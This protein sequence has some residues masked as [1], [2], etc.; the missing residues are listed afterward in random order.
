MLDK[1]DLV[2]RVKEWRKSSEAG[3]LQWIAWVDEKGENGK[4][5]PAFYD[6]AFLDEFLNSA[7][8][9]ST[10]TVTVA[11]QKQEFLQQPTMDP[12]KEALVRDIK[13]RQRSN[14]LKYICRWEEYCVTYAPDMRGRM[15]PERHEVPFLQAFLRLEEQRR[16]LV[17][18]NYS[19]PGS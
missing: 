16:R 8:R 14:D 12:L 18:A 17:A 4:R 5:D 13:Q 1:K 10:A 6:V 7:V 3:K 9:R 2:S 15:D 11:P 19:G